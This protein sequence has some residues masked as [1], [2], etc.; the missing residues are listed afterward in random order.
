[1]PSHISRAVKL[2]RENLKEVSDR[3]AAAL[4]D[5]DEYPNLFPDL[6]WALKVEEIFRSN[7]KNVLPASSYLTV[8][9]CAI[10]VMYGPRS[11]LCDVRDT[12]Y[13]RVSSPSTC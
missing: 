5:P 3:A 9:T 12:T 4:A 10:V 7:R 2:W 8:M 13:P 11:C 1:M 6:E